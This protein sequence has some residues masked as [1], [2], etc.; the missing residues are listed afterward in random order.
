MNNPENRAGAKSNQTVGG[1]PGSAAPPGK[2]VKTTV[3]RGHAYMVPRLYNVEIT[4]Q[5]AVRGSEVQTRAQ[6]LVK[7]GWQL[8][9]NYEYLLAR[10]TLG[11]YERGRIAAGTSGGMAEAQYV[12]FGGGSVDVTYTLAEGQILAVSANGE[13]EY[14]IRAT[15]PGCDARSVV[16]ATADGRHLTIAGGA[17][18]VPLQRDGHRHIVEVVLGGTDPRPA[19]RSAAGEER[20]P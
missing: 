14:E 6:K 8:K 16:A 17:A 7:P 5:E 1:S 4:L 18:R 11:Y 13:T 19:G 3:E 2:T 12:T 10:L 9:D 15:N 20:R